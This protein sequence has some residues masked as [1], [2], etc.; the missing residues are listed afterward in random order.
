MRLRAVI[1]TISAT[2]QAFGS[3]WGDLILESIYLVHIAWM[4]A[5]RLLQV[6]ACTRGAEMR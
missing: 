5:L 4:V 3:D 2:I 6:F 1:F